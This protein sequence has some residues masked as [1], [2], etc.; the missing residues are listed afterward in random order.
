MKNILILSLIA[1][2]TSC[3]TTSTNDEDARLTALDKEFD[4]VENNDFIHEKEIPFNAISD[5][6]IGEVSNYDSLAKE[7]IARLPEP[8]LMVVEKKGETISKVVSLCYQKRFDEAFNL[9]DKKYRLYKKHPSYWNQVGT[10]YLIKGDRRKALLFYNKSRDLKSNYAPPINNLGVL[11]LREGQDQKAL[12]AFKKASE[13]KSFSMTP[14]FNMSQLY[15]KY[16]QIK[17]AKTLLAAL[18]RKSSSDQDVLSSLGT[19]YLIEGN[20]K[21]ASALFSKIKSELHIHPAIGINFSLALKLS[22][23]PN[24]AK[25]VLS[26]I[27]QSQ[28]SGLDEY[29]NKARNFVGL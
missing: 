16:G 27:D 20:S 8:K 13:V 12:A 6:Y 4:W 15:L 23:R 19:A 29:Y 18:Y 25:T 14:I 1:L 26:N 7:S 21:K 9:L 11:Y 5:E 28:L 2:L 24:D 17:K 22:G 10:C 3:G